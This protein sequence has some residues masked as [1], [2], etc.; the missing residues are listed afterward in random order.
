VAKN[1]VGPIVVKTNAQHQL[2][3][4]NEVPNIMPKSISLHENQL[5]LHHFVHMQNTK[6][7]SYFGTNTLVF[8]NLNMFLGNIWCFTTKDLMKVNRS[9]ICNKFLFP[10]PRCWLQLFKPASPNIITWSTENS[11]LLMK[12]SNDDKLQ[13]FTFLEHVKRNNNWAAYESGSGSTWI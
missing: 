5:E 12:S 8:V 11:S 4:R 3:Y 9:K 7:G 2:S 6:Q 13:S 1:D 10:R